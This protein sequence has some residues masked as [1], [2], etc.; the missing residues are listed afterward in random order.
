[1]STETPEKRFVRLS[2]VAEA[3]GTSY[4]IE[5]A[6]EWGEEIKALHEQGRLKPWAV[7][8]AEARAAIAAM[9]PPPKD[10]KP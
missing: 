9:A 5:S 4:E 6:K 3:N 10:P 8:N 1:M 2:A 7:L